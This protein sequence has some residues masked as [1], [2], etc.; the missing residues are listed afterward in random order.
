MTIVILIRDAT[1]VLRRWKLAEIN[2]AV[3]SGDEMAER[4][5]LQARHGQIWNTAQLAKE[6]EILGFMAPYVIV[7]RKCDGRKGSLEFQ[8]QP[9]FYFN[10]VLD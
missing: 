6:F 8:H 3:Q 5:R 10:F 2:H 4:Q 1:E 7:R 9:R